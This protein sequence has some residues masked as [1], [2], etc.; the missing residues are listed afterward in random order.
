MVDIELPTQEEFRKIY[1]LMRHGRYLFVKRV[2]GLKIKQKI[3]P[4]PG[5]VLQT[6]VLDGDTHHFIYTDIGKFKPFIFSK[7]KLDKKLEEIFS[8]VPKD[9]VVTDER[10]LESMEVFNSGLYVT[11]GSYPIRRGLGEG[12]EGAEFRKEDKVVSFL[13]EKGK[14]IPK[15]ETL[16]VFHPLCPLPV[17]AL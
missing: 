4:P 9:V 16:T 1:E 10:E 14:H 3:D 17:F 5:F 12:E 8:F 6:L 11:Y 15:W 13:K 2:V 7:K